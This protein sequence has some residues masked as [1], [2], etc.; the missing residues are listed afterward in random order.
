[1]IKE[2]GCHACVPCMCAEETLTIMPVRYCKVCA[3]DVPASQ[4]EQHQAWHDSPS[5]VHRAWQRV[6]MAGCFA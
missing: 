3:A 4:A 2:C 5:Q 6:G 1:V